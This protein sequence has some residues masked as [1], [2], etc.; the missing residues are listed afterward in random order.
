MP[1]QYRSNDRVRHQRVCRAEHTDPPSARLFLC[2]RCRAQAL[3][4]GCCDRGQIY[5]AGDCAQQARRGAQCAAGRRYQ[6]SWSGRLSH[7][8]RSRRYRARQKNVTH[9]GSPP[10]P[11]NDLL[12]P[13]STTTPSDAALPGDARPQH[14]HW[15]GGRCAPL[16]RQGFLR[17]RGPRRGVVRHA[18]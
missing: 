2:V 9:Q 8:E 15:C 18:R 3:I 17:R 5:C 13:A 6:M 10:P 1:G 12:A 14:C 16:V 7:A 4:C 11:S